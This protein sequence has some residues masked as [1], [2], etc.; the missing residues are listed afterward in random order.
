MVSVRFTVTTSG[1]IA[2]CRIARS[3]GSNVLDNAT[4]RLLIRRLRF[5][6]AT[7][8]NGGPV[9]TEIGSDYTWGVRQHY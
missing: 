1:E 9:A 2:N 6:P 3:S 7:D 8:G 4:C 5:R